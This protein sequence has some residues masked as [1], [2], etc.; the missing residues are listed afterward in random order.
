[1]EKIEK[2]SM[3]VVEEG[4]NSGGSRMC[5]QNIKKYQIKQSWGKSITVTH[6]GV[7]R[8][9]KGDFCY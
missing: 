2:K 3:C 7:N 4:M 9:C 6:A 5:E 1:M 8:H